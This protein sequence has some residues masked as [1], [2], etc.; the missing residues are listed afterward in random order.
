MPGGL[1]VEGGQTL[2][3]APVA[4]PPPQRQPSARAGQGGYESI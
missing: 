4:R 2:G 3:G 1:D